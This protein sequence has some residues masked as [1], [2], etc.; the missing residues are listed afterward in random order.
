M[1]TL[2]APL[3]FDPP[4]DIETYCALGWHL[5]PIPSGSKAPTSQGWNLRENCITDP[6][7]FPDGTNVGLAHA[8]SGTCS[9]DIDN[10]LL[11]SQWLSDRGVGLSEL[12]TAPG[13]VTIASGRPGRAKALYRLPEGLGPLLTKKILVDGK[14]AL[15]LRCATGDGKTVQDVLPPSSHPDTGQPYCWGLPDGGSLGDYLRGMPELPASLLAIWREQIEPNRGIAKTDITASDGAA[16]WGMI[17]SALY[18]I[19]PDCSREEW[20]RV[21]MA[22]HHD[23]EHTGDPDKALAIFSEWSAGD[24]ANPPENYKGERDIIAQWKSFR[25]DQANGVTLGSLFEVAKGYGWTRPPVDASGLFREVATTVA[26]ASQTLRTTCAADIRP[27]VL[28]WIWEGVLPKGKI[29]TIAGDPGVGKGVLTARIAATVSSG[30]NW[31]PSQP[32]ERGSVAFLAQEDAKEDTMVPR[33]MAAGADLTRV[34]FIEGVAV[35]NSTGDIPFNLEESAPLLDAW[36]ADNTDVTLLII[37]PINDFLGPSTDSYKDA[38][39][40]QILNPLKIMAERHNVTIIMVSHMNKGSGKANYRIMGAMAFT[41]VARITMIITKDEADNAR[42]LILPVK[43]NIAKDT[44]GYSYRIQESLVQIR[45]DD[46]NAIWTPQP[47]AMIDNES[48]G[49][50]AEQVL[51]GTGGNDLNDDIRIFLETELAHGAVPAKEMQSRCKNAGL[52]YSTV[53]KRKD[54]FGVIS[55]KEDPA[56]PQSPWIWKFKNELPDGLDPGARE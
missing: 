19:P 23:G 4:A 30:V 13:A 16:D 47:V 39:V 27:K 51:N 54:Q 2:P 29:V 26:P 42:R 52:S 6:A 22:L 11:A 50:T 28:K 32:C 56:V 15:E 20:L 38:E 37:D 18:A 3:R 14:T 49:H 55:E 1:S 45:D 8:Y 46:A 24:P 12:L 35:S 48:H 40:R 17:E 53:L 36:L 21:G 5:V 25:A 44:S 9:L 10:W 31:R 41:G 34:K 33:L 43:A 7:A